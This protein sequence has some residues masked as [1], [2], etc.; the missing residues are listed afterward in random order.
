MWGMAPM[1]VE[2]IYPGAR[3]IGRTNRFSAIAL[4]TSAFSGLIQTDLSYTPLYYETLCLDVMIPW[5]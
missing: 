1:L 2:G 3:T 4:V 5:Y